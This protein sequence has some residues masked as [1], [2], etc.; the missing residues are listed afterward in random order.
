[1]SRKEREK[2]NYIR[3]RLSQDMGVLDDAVLFTDEYWQ[4]IDTGWNT[5]KGCG[6][7]HTIPDMNIDWEQFDQIIEKFRFYKT[8]GIMDFEDEEKNE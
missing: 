1:M 7:E 2:D 3:W 5:I 4:G 6:L 8:I